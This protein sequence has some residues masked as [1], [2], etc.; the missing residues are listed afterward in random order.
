M[1]E[2]NKFQWYKDDFQETLVKKEDN[3][4][5]NPE[6]FYSESII[7]KKKKRKKVTLN[8]KRV[9]IISLIVGIIIFGST[10]AFINPIIKD[11][12]SKPAEMAIAADDSQEEDLEVENKAIELNDTSRKE[13]TVKDINK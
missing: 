3:N 11:N 8:R 6:C 13:L 5:N 1:N 12:N 4:Y 7:E 9:A 2:N 10:L